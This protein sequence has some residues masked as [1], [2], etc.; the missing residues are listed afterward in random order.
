[1]SILQKILFS[2]AVKKMF[3]DGKKVRDG[4]D[5]KFPSAVALVFALGN[6]F[7]VLMQRKPTGHFH[8]EI[9]IR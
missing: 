9:F 2:T 4:R 3:R 6:F 7:R 5:V 8:P 1:M